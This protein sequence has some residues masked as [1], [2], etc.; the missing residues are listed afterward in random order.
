MLHAMGKG[1]F[2]HLLLA[3]SL[4]LG[5][6]AQDSVYE[7]VIQKFQKKKKA[8]WSFEDSG[9]RRIRNPWNPWQGIFEIAVDLH[10]SGGEFK[11]GG[12]TPVDESSAVA[13]GGVQFHFSGLGLGIGREQSAIREKG[14]IWN[15][16]EGTL[17][18]RLLGSS[19]QSTQITLLGGIY[20]V[21]H[22]VFGKYDQNF[23]GAL[24]NLYFTRYLGLEVQ[25]RQ[26]S[27]ASSDNYNLSGLDYHYGL[28]W[29]ATILRVYVL[30]RHD[31]LE[32]E[33]KSTG[34]KTPESLKGTVFGGRLYF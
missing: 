33:Q 21:D 19:T 12:A 6:Q 30:Y 3:L 28:F 1:R 32:G 27:A 26:R 22:R 34:D 17:Y 9:K 31:Y 10:M 7:P 25:A 15:R 24:G 8:R 5:V 23:Y 16:D 14:S 4:P 18:L 13:G 29:E 2:W 11:R 20:K